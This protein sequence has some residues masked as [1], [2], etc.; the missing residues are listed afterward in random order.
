LYRNDRDKAVLACP[1]HLLLDNRCGP[2][3]GACVTT[4]DGSEREAA[5][6]LLEVS[7]RHHV[8]QS[9]AAVR[10]LG[11]SPHVAVKAQYNAIDGRITRTA[12]YL[13]S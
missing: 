5:Q 11:V 9:A 3:Q 10:Q 12:G 6:L 1:T 13:I 7:G 4:A 2:V 8:P